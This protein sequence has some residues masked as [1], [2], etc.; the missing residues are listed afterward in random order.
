M[1]SINYKYHIFVQN[2]NNFKYSLTKEVKSH[3][4]EWGKKG[5]N[6]LFK[7]WA[8]QNSGNLF[9]CR[10]S[11]PTYIKKKK[12]NALDYDKVV[13]VDQSLPILEMINVKKD[14]IR[15]NLTIITSL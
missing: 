5:K 2:E 10:N 11:Y 1:T 14:P 6:L 9:Q 12:T 15:G 7:C 4:E 8:E 13:D 3:C